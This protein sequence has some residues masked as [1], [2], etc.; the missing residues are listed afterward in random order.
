[1][2][3]GDRANREENLFTEK[4]KKRLEEFEKKY[5]RLRTE[6]DRY[7]RKVKK[8]SSKHKE[9]SRK[10]L[11]Q[12][13]VEYLSN[14][15]NAMVSRTVLAK[16]VLKY[17]ELATL[18]KIFPAIELDTIYDEALANRRRQ[19]THHFSA[20]DE[21]VLSMA[22]EGNINAATLI[23]KKFESLDNKK[24]EHS[25]DPSILKHILD[26]LPDEFRLSV[27]KKLEDKIAIKV[28]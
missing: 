2:G 24:V 26:A 12:Q 7:V 15:E 8:L 5:P 11:R 10:L 14:T 17:S 21:K 1:M 18:Y 20:I 4:Q 3:Y 13:I 6:S 28:E 23:Y 22:E 16:K 25:F 9:A 19:Y 27:L